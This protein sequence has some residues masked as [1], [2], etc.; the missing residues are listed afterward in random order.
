MNIEQRLSKLESENRTWRFV[1]IFLVVIIAILSN[2]A[3]DPG[4]R[5]PLSPPSAS[6]ADVP[7]ETSAKNLRV[8]EITIVNERGEDVGSVGAGGGRVPRIIFRNP[9]NDLQKIVLSPSGLTAYSELAITNISPGIMNMSALNSELVRDYRGAAERRDR[10]LEGDLKAFADLTRVADNKFAKM[11]ADVTPSIV[12]AG[13]EGPSGGEIR[14]YNPLAKCV[15]SIQSSKTN[16]GWV[17]VADVN[18]KM[19]RVLTPR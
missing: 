15:V 11:L 18:G 12:L 3:S 7:A 6:A 19:T 9:E 8:Q 14:I 5:L 2:Y 1:A 10:A 17:G 4:S 16:E 13:G